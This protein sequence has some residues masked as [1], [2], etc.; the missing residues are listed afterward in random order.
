MLYIS[1]DMGGQMGLFMG[2]SMI[3]LAEIFFTICRVFRSLV[4]KIF[5]LAKMLHDKLKK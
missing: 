5:V 1:G 3:T 2:A 4:Y